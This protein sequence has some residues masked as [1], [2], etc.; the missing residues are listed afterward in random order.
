VAEEIKLAPGWLKEDLA[1]AARRLEQFRKAEET[2][3]KPAKK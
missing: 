2:V 1:I 3:T